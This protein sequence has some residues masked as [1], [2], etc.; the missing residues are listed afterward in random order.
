MINKCHISYVCAEMLEDERQAEL[1]WL[2]TQP[3]FTSK[4]AGFQR[5][6]QAS[7]ADPHHFTYSENPGVHDKGK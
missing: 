2:Q 3:G 6:Q 1:G 4:L 5:F 7:S